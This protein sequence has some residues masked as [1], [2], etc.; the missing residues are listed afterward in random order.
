MV[1]LKDHLKIFAVT[2]LTTDGG[3]TL[4][5]GRLNHWMH[6]G[7]TLQVTVVLNIVV[8]TNRIGLDITVLQLKVYL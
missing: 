6:A 8:L 2:R 7:N 1:K 5:I 3:N 4:E